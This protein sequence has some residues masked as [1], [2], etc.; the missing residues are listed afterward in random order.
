MDWRVCEIIDRKYERCVARVVHRLRRLPVDRLYGD[1]GPLTNLWEY[2]V[3]EWQREGHSALLF[4]ALERTIHSF[5]VAVVEALPQEEQMLLYMVTREAEEEEIDSAQDSPRLH[6]N[7]SAIEREL[8]SRLNA[9]ACDEPLNARLENWIWGKDLAR[10]E[11]DHDLH[12]RDDA[13]GA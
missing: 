8:W 3:A 6:I 12:R 11:E 13:Q 2:W 9:R 4:E 1:G 10:F 5:V 7:Q